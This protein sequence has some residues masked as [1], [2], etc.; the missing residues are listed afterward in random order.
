PLQQ[1]TTSQSRR[2]GRIVD[3]LLALV[4]V[5]V[6]VA[7]VFAPALIARIRLIA[8]SSAAARGS[9]AAAVHQVTKPRET[10]VRHVIVPP[11]AVNRHAQAAAAKAPA[12]HAT[13]A[14]A[15]RATLPA[16][17]LAVHPAHIA[18]ALRLAPQARPHTGARPSISSSTA[19]QTAQQHKA[20]PQSKADAA[21]SVSAQS[22][23]SQANE[24]T[25]S[26]PNYPGRQ[27]PSGPVWTDNGPPGLSATPGG[28]ILGGGAAGH[29]VFVPRAS[30]SPS[31]GDFF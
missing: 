2:S 23:S 29:P 6:M 13:Q 5:A 8:A 15:S 3:A 24:A 17:R 18:K 20:A 9:S 7:S 28:L 10:I 12:L 19:V 4:L 26:D 27:V 16:A 14:V 30:C 25:T 1:P 31:R 22:A 21:T 11:Q